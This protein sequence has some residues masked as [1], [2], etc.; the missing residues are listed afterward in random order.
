[1]DVAMSWGAHFLEFK[2][3]FC[4]TDKTPVSA[5]PWQRTCCHDK[6]RRAGRKRAST[7]L[8]YTMFDKDHQKMCMT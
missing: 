2:M 6:F 1:L 3:I 4:Y 7:V 8:L 5:K